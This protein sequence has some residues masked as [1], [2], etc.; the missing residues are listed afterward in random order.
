M[1]ELM[2]IL[3]ALVGFGYLAKQRK[4][5]SVAAVKPLEWLVMN[6][7]VPALIVL[8]FVNTPLK[9]EHLSLIGLGVLSMVVSILFYLAVFKVLIPD[10]EMYG[11]AVPLAFFSNAGFM[12]VPIMQSLF[13]A[14]G[15][16]LALPFQLFSHGPLWLFLVGGI[17]FA[18]FGEK[19]KKRNWGRIVLNVVLSPAVLAVFAGIGMF[20][21]MQSSVV[22]TNFGRMFEVIVKT[23]EFAAGANTFLV[24]FLVGLMLSPKQFSRKLVWPLML[25]VVANLLVTPL[26]TYL[27]GGLLALEA[28][29]LSVAAMES[30]MP[31]AVLA[32]VL[33]KEYKLNV[34][35][36][37]GVLFVSTV[38][39]L[40][41][42]PLVKFLLFG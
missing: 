15:V 34:E 27:L 30:A 7:T 3:F 9:V 24:M 33:V 18:Y 1:I 5:V 22:M 2:I 42:L 26:I 28:M 29:S 6:V 17:L 36:A 38:A 32:L 19:G 37:E 40:A 35:M 21:L 25:V 20:F 39:S 13:G 23:L 41:T 16:S 11:T 31:M 14:E 12:G 10:R 8:S 4:W